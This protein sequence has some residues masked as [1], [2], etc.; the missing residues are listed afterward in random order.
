VTAQ[1]RRRV[2]LAAAVAGVAVLL[3]AATFVVIDHGR[4]TAATA[5]PP[6]SVRTIAVRKTDLSNTQS[7]TGTLGFGA[8]QPLKGAGSGVVTKLPN[9][10]EV[11]QRGKPLYSVDGKPVPVFFGDTPFFRKLDNPELK[12][13]DIAVLADNLAALGYAV[14]ARAKDRQQ[15]A[16][17]PALATALKKW[18]KKA[19]L[20]DTG[21]LD[22][23]QVVVLPGPARV[24]SVTAQPGDPAAGPLLTWTST[25]KVITA[26]V[27]A[28][29][30]GAVKT[31]AAVTVVRPDGKEIPAKVTAVSTTVDNNSSSGQQGTGGPPKVTITLT[32]DDTQSV[33]DLDSASV[34][35]KIATE[36]H[37]G[38]LAVPVG[39]LLALREGGYAVQLPDG[40]LKPV[41]TGMFAR[42]Q[43]EI[44]GPGITEGLGVVTTS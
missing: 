36:T 31:G 29:D 25:A 19:G 28:A 9:T 14:G 18:Q 6:P 37:E 2:V 43:V 10:G 8:P 23:G 3:G 32:P 26:P 1:T 20:D 22:A 16:F 13:P 33:A 38:V 34:Q 24:N 11:A 7:F 44:S 42:D 4:G 41:K 35:V 27:D 21:T 39:A 30:A 5:A 40:T 12:G 17:T 15:A